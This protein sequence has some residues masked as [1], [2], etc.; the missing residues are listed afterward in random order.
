MIE[1]DDITLLRE[2]SATESE[3][4][5]AA[6][7][8]RHL[9]LVY[10][11]ALRS[12]GNVHAAQEISQAVFIILARKAAN[13]PQ[14]AVLSGWLYQTTRLTAANF[15]RGEIRRQQREQEAYMQSTLTEPDANVWPQIA[16]LLDDALGKLGERD[17]NA[18]VLRFFENKSLQEVGA[19][20]GA[21][22]DAAKIRVSRA[23]EKLRKIFGKRG[24]TLSAMLIAGA[25]SAGSVQ[26]APVGLA[27]TVTAAAAKGAAISGST[28]TLVKGALKIMAWT[29][30][31]TAVVTSTAMILA[32]I[33]IVTVANNLRHGPPRQTGSMK[34][35]IGNVTPMIGY[36]LSRAGIILASD[37]SL[38][39]WGEE[40]LGWPVLGLNNTNIQNTV[41]LR[42][43]GHESDW[44]NVAVGGEHCLAIKADGTLWAWGGNYYY[45]LGDGTDITRPTPMPSIPGNDWKQAAA[46]GSTSFA[47]KN[48][49]TLWAWGQLGFG[50][51]G[52]SARAVQV[53]TSTNWMKIWAGD[54]QFVGLQSDGSLWFWGS[55]SGELKDLPKFPIPTRISPDTNWIDVC[56]GY[57]TMFAIKSDGTLWSWGLEASFY[58][59]SPDATSNANPLQVGTE[60][61]WQSCASSG[62]FYQLL[63]K[64]DG[65]LWA[66]DASEHQLVKPASDYKPV[67]FRKIDFHKNI[68]AYM[69]GGV[70]FGVVV[71]RDGEVWTWGR[72]VGE[73]SPKDYWGPN[74]E[75]LF[76][77]SRVIAK[78][79]QLSNVD[80]AD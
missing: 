2:F 31:K 7:V 80:S 65:S 5:F 39:S 17:R 73:L 74:H 69:A 76:P 34:L 75:Q 15:L 78:P 14:H 61:D 18:I 56:F 40:R 21:S 42:R 45:Q 55:L 22:E 26:A 67:K 46:G 47:L 11:V 16:P 20:L 79:W 54:I 36:G 68:A 29:K 64:K 37:G 23:L 28:L 38:W 6:L 41:S 35:P 27:V 4:A 49:G 1:R 13:W 8:S 70:D 77:K 62:G 43:I 33:G 71:T 51:I 30:A 60:N 3:A 25:V 48:E 72:V 19:G 52:E 59:Q 63:E 66:L 32:M 58:T 50:N 12:T 53:G 24:L 57:Y 44:V 10:S 9:N